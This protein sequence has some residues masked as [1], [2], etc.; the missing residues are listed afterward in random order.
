MPELTELSGRFDDQGN[1]ELVPVLFLHAYPYQRTMWSPQVQALAG[2]ARLLSLD[3]RGH[4]PGAPAPAA[5][6]LE[7]LV[8]DALALL[9]Q[10]GIERCVLCGLSM[11]G[12]IALRLYQ[13]APER[14][15][16]LL[17]S[18]IQAPA[19]SNPSKEAR[20]AGL[21]LLW[22]EGVAAFAEM[23]LK[24]QLS[25]TTHERAPEVVEKLRRMIVALTPEVLSASMVALA[26]R[27]DLTELLPRVSVPTAVVIGEHDP[28]TPP[29]AAR[30][31]ADGIPG[32]T[33]Q[34]LPGAGHIA[35]LEAEPEFTSALRALLA[36]TR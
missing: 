26:T 6:M 17:L 1:V 24:R 34:V 28:I 8:D 10:R 5:Y 9:D 12:Y 2:E 36:R 3:V 31:L 33:L 11:G 27:P 25:P 22:K 19:D 16:G 23:Q 29:A 35:N 21:R 13:R 15:R 18:N 14:V 30:A 32:A 7:H 4:T 20:A